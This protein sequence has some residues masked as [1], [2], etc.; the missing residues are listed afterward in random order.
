MASHDTIRKAADLLSR[1]HRRVDVA[2]QLGVSSATIDRWR[3]EKPALFETHEPGS[4]DHVRQVLIDAL[5]RGSL[6]ERVKAAD[7]LQRMGLQGES[8]PGASV[9]V[10]VSE[11]ETCP[12]CGERLPVT[13]S[14]HAPGHDPGNP[15]ED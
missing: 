7:M 15:H 1:G 6:S 5:T 14:G 12:A 8:S 4:P 2:R 9:T 3:R 10:I 11:L 13:V